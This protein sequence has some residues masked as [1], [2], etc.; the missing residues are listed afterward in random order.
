MLGDLLS[1]E[2]VRARG[3]FNPTV[4][5]ELKQ[6]HLSETRSHSDRLWTLMIT[7]LWMQQYLD[8]QGLW[9]FS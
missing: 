7:E 5:E 2:R 8:G 9:S 6:E 1:P 4:V 3:L